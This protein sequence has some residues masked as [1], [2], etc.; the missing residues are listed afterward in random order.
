[1]ELSPKF[2]FC[3]NLKEINIIQQK[4]EQKSTWCKE[5]AKV[6]TLLPQISNVVTF[7][8]ESVETMAMLRHQ[9]KKGKQ[10]YN[11]VATS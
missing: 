11:N 9:L 4:K 1:M 10:R 5:R 3:R 8:G 2:L 6:A 7:C